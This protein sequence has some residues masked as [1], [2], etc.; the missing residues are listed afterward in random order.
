MREDG[1]GFSWN[2]SLGGYGPGGENCHAVD[3][4]ARVRELLASARIY[5]ELMTSFAG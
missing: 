2:T 3:E 1:K 4:R 5:A